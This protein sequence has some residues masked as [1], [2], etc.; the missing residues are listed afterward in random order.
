MSR[1]DVWL[2]DVRIGFS[3][4]GVGSHEHLGVL[5]RLIV[6]DDFHCTRQNE[7]PASPA[8]RS[9]N[10]QRTGVLGCVDA[11]R[12]SMSNA[13]HMTTTAISRT[14]CLR[15]QAISYGQVGAQLFGWARIHGL[16]SR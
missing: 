14:Y 11:S 12:Y 16:A 8:T 9:N 10:H 1:S 6:L 4:G 15:S 13:L 3:L 5:L 2:L 7:R